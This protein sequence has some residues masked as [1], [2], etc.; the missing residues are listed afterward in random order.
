MRRVIAVFVALVAMLVMATS[1]AAAPPAG[2]H[3]PGDS[4]GEGAPTGSVNSVDGAGS[5]DATD[6]VTVAWEGDPGVIT[7]TNEGD[8]DVLV[9]L[10]VKSGNDVGGEG[11]KFVVFNDVLVEAGGDATLN[12][13][14]EVSY[15]VVYDVTEVT[16]PEE[17]TAAAASVTPPSCTAAGTLVVPANTES[18]T[19]SVEPAYT[20]GATGTFV[21]TATAAS[22][23][24]VL[25]GTTSWTLTVLPQLTN[26]TTASVPSLAPTPSQPLVGGGTPPPP[27]PDTA[28]ATVSTAAPYVLGML[29]V[30]SLVAMA[31]VRTRRARR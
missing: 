2:T 19:Y 30:L 27:V 29:L 12:I 9:D 8:L 11:I 20:A 26:C 28:M 1:V 31:A 10:C 17:V 14:K 16:P 21:V 22:D 3:C 23:D 4:E 15:L 24:F 25:I 18:V 13:S 5:I 7:I 6:D